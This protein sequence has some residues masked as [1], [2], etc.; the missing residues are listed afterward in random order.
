MSQ[1]DTIAAIATGMTNS[2]IGIIRMSGNQAIE[3]ADQVFRS[4]SGQKVSEMQSHTIHYG[5]IFDQDEMIDEIMLLIMKAPQSF[6]T[7]DTIEIDCHGGV[8]VM[9]RILETVIKNGARP[10]EPGEFTKRAFLNGRID[11][12]KAEAIMDLIHSQNEYAHH[13]SISQIRGSLYERIV[14]VREKLLYEIAMIESALDD[15]EHISL[16]GYSERLSSIIN[17]LVKELN[18]LILTFDNGRILQEGIRTVIVGKPNVGKSSL[19]NIMVGEERAIVT[20][21]AGTTRDVIEE[22]INLEGINLRILDTAG[23]RDT[24]DVVEKIGVERAKKYADEADL[25]IYIVD[26][27]NELDENDHEIMKMIQEKNAVVLLN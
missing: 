7:E 20:D 1:N 19:L 12:T 2:G 22:T 26:A 15:P 16:D 3:I 18:Q 11:L 6:T 13:N 25:I 21:I 23:I 27:S 10:A 24:N 5:F 4:K 14:K 8:Y 17:G 9:K